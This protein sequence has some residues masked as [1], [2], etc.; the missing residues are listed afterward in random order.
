MLGNWLESGG[1][2][3]LDPTEHESMVFLAGT[4]IPFVVDDVGCLVECL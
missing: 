2:D 1:T 4:S 3:L